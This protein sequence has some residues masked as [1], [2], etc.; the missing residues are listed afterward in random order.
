MELRIDDHTVIDGRMW[1]V[2]SSRSLHGMNFATR[3]ISR[4]AKNNKITDSQSIVLS[5]SLSIDTPP[6][7]NPG[8]MVVGRLL[9]YWEGSFSGASC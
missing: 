5:F 8:K 3:S 2:F 4:C 7:F 1:L 6:K 9:S